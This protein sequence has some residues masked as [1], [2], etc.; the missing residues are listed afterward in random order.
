MYEYCVACCL[1]PDK[2]RRAVLSPLCVRIHCITPYFVYRFAVLATDPGGGA[3]QSERPTGGPV[4]GGDRPVRAV[5]DQV[6]HQLA[7]GAEREQVPE[8]GTEALLR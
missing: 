4:R 3:G 2:V 8:S 1:N 7:V 6:S 5:P